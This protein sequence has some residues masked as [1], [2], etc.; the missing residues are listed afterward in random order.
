MKLS[1]SFKQE[2]LS[3]IMGNAFDQNGFNKFILSEGIVGIFKEP[4]KL[5]SGRESNWYVNWRRVVEDVYKTDILTSHIIQ[6][7]ESLGLN[8]DCFFGVPEGATKAAVLTQDKWAKSRQDYASGRYVLPMGRGKIKEHGDPRDR[9]FLAAPRG[10]T[11][12]LEDVT[13][14]GG[15]VLSTVADLKTLDNVAVMA[16]IGFTNRMEVTPIPGKDSEDTV[17]KFAEIYER[18]TGQKYT[19][20]M[21]VE[22]ALDAAGVKYHALSKGPDLLPQVFSSLDYSKSDLGDKLARS[23]EAE[24]KEFGVGELKLV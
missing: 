8:P 13:T 7:V 14:T 2:I 1:N 5:V 4:K 18:A 23:I 12:V 10:A 19:T 17:K 6:F 3:L 21:S 24:F 11:I 20:Q 15:S 16:V 9:Y 22:Q